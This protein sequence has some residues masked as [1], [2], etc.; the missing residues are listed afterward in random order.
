METLILAE[1]Q[2]MSAEQDGNQSNNALF[3]HGGSLHLD[4]WLSSTD[5][6]PLSQCD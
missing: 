1:A 6:N 5:H 3:F 4:K 2:N